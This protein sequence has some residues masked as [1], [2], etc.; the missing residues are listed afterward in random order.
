M[1]FDP[2]EQQILRIALLDL[3]TGMTL[4]RFFEHKRHKLALENVLTGRDH[5]FL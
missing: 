1:L 3:P 4:V 2:L 5:E